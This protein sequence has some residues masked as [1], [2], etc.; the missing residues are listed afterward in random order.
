LTGRIPDFS[1]I[2]GPGQNSMF[3]GTFGNCSSLTG[4]IPSN[5][6]SGITSA[7]YKMFLYTFYGCSSLTGDIPSFKNVVF[8]GADGEN[9]QSM[10]ER[11]FFECYGLDGTIPSDA[12]DGIKSTAPYMFSQTFAESSKLKGAIPDFSNIRGPGK[13]GMFAATFY[14]CSGLDGIIPLDAFAGINSTAPMMFSNTFSGCSKLKQMPDANGAIHN[15]IDGSF[16]NNIY[17]PGTDYSA[18]Y[19]MSYMFDDSGF[20]KPCPANT[21]EVKPEFGATANKPWC[22]P[23]PNE[24]YY[25]PADHD[26]VGATSPDQC[27]LENY[28]WN[29]TTCVGKTVALSYIDSL[30]NSTIDTQPQMCTYGESFNLPSAPTKSGF[31][32]V[33]WELVQ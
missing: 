28:Y 2:R 33:G 24:T 16:L 9:A 15:Y 7:A 14:H 10:F 25:D 22:T 12:F 1:N 27:C 13:E 18:N 17:T 5:T 19:V 11:T 20:D 8:N 30:D 6:F 23:C 4:P 21:Y 26:G 3:S 31:V 29:G 32:F